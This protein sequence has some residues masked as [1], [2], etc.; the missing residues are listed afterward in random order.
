MKDDSSRATAAILYLLCIAKN[1]CG[2]NLRE[3]NLFYKLN[4]W[5]YII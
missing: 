4:E 1:M 5:K 3:K 2:N